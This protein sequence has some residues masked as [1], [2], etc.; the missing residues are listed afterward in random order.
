MNIV[1][2]HHY[3]NDNLLYSLTYKVSFYVSCY[4]IEE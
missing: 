2:I 3:D 1:T 4:R